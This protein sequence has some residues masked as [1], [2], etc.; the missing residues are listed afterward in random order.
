MQ[1]TRI[2]AGNRKVLFSSR[3]TSSARVIAHQLYIGVATMPTPEHSDNAFTDTR[4]ERVSRSPYDRCVGTPGITE[5]H[6]F[7]KR[8][9]F[10][11]AGAG[12]EAVAEHALEWTLS[13]SETELDDVA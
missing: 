8:A 1:D 3:L 12:W 13:R 7:A 5:L 4:L 6:Y 9:H 11:G 2:I 10:A